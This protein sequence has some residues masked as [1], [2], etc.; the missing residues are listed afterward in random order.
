LIYLIGIIPSIDNWTTQ[1]TFQ[2]EK[3]KIEDMTQIDMSQTDIDLA[4]LHGEDISKLKA[5]RLQEHKK[6][7]LLELDE[8]YGIKRDET[9]NVVENFKP[10]DKPKSKQDLWEL[11]QGKGLVK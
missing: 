9:E 5:D 3:Q 7:L 1:V 2:T 6:Q 8:T 11:L 4:I 10:D